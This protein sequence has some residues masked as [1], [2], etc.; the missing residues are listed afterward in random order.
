VVEAVEC[1][2]EVGVITAPPVERDDARSVADLIA[3]D[4]TVGEGFQ[5]GMQ[6]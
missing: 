2:G 5:Q 3:E 6:R 4:G 1:L